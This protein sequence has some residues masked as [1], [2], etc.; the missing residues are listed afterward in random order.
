MQ[1]EIQVQ[2]TMVE[3][4][5]N[6]VGGLVG[7]VAGG[8]CVHRWYTRGRGGVGAKHYEEEEKK[9]QEEEAET[10]AGREKESLTLFFLKNKSGVLQSFHYKCLG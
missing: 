10:Q 4:V 5:G 6:D 9:T 1:W 8:V 7:S 2:V 3:E